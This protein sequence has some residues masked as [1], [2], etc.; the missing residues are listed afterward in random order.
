LRSTGTEFETLTTSS[1]YLKECQAT[2][3]PEKYNGLIQ[4]LNNAILNSWGDYS[5]VTAYTQPYENNIL[6]FT[7]GIQNS[8][9]YNFVNHIHTAHA[10]NES[11]SAS[12]PTGTLIMFPICIKAKQ[13]DSEHNWSLSS[14]IDI[15]NRLG[16][17]KYNV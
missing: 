7:S 12:I 1:I 3:F 9:Y 8:E 10:I 2:L 15:P 17:S 13:N 4:R 14:L 16:T 11:L 6:D 5:Q